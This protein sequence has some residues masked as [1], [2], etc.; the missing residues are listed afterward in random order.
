M[1]VDVEVEC[2]GGS[3]A[4]MN[5]GRG[6]TSTT[7]PCLVGLCG[8]SSTV[9]GKWSRFSNTWRSFMPS[10]CE[11]IVGLTLL[12][13]VVMVTLSLSHLLV[14]KIPINSVY[15]EFIS[16]RSLP[17]CLRYLPTRGKRGTSFKVRHGLPPRSKVG[18]KHSCCPQR[19]FRN[20]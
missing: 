7:V 17:L 3:I 14:L 12:W 19:P 5:S 9:W 8:G 15:N 16:L 2:L 20:R 6:S 10:C 13:Q 18:Q 1:G 11:E 4:W